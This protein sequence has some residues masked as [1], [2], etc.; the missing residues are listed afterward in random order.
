MSFTLVAYQV[1]KLSIK[2]S[3]NTLLRDHKL[4]P[5]KLEESLEKLDDERRIQARFLLKTIEIL[6]SLDNTLEKARILNAAAYFIH[7][8]IAK[9]YNWVSP[10]RSSLY[11]SLNSSL[12]LKPGNQ[13]ERDDLID[14]YGPLE[15]FLRSN[16]YVSA[17]PKKGYLKKQP[18]DIAGYEVEADIITL[19]TQVQGWRVELIQ[20]ARE[21]HLKEQ[22]VKKPVPE[23]KKPASKGYFGGFFGGGTPAEEG[24]VQQTTSP[25]YV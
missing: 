22:G 20:A 15:K 10:E 2:E 8:K 25:S 19:S 7:Q 11:R 5:N 6:D 21:L 13:P 24:K 3:V 12:D 1:L 16:V 9:S 4:D 14:M 23:A 18:F 17:D